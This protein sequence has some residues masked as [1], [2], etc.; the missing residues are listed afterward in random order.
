MKQ[1]HIDQISA[2]AAAVADRL[3]KGEIKN[4]YFVACGGS[5]ASMMPA[6]YMFDRELDIPSAI[7]TSNEFTYGTLRALVLN[8]WLLPALT[9][10]Q[11]LKQLRL[12]RKQLMRVHFR[13]R[14]LT[15]RIRRFGR[16]PAWASIMITVRK[17]M[18]PIRAALL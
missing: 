15:W 9:L 13:L 17:P 1:E 14:F 5:Q 4:V 16:L 6:Q 2:A 18:S 11:L 8:L 10:A 12:L 7:Y 3:A